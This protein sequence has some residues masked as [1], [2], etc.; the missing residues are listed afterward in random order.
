MNADC[1]GETRLTT[2]G[3]DDSEPDWQPLLQ[4]PI[5]GV[6]VPL[7]KITVIAPYIVLA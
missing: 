1:T 4:A 7:N 2:S 3:N 6:V 5:G